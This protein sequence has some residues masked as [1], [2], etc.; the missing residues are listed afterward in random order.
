MAMSN[1]QPLKPNGQPKLGKQRRDFGDSKNPYC[2]F[3]SDRERRAAL[4]SRDVRLVLIAVV[5]A[6]GGLTDGS[7]VR[8]LLHVF[9]AW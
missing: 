5:F 1:E 2:A 9:S 6:I 7:E 3:R 8:A 4:V